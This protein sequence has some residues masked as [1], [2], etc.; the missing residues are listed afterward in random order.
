MKTDSPHEHQNLCDYCGADTCDGEEC[1]VE[2]LRL[3]NARL[4]KQLAEADPDAQLRAMSEI[5]EVLGV[6]SQPMSSE[7]PEIVAKLIRER[8]EARAAL[9]K[10]GEEYERTFDDAD[11]YERQANDLAKIVAKLTGEE[12]G[13]HSNRNCP[14]SR[15]IEA[16][17]DAIKAAERA[18]KE[19]MK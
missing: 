17:R 16:G 8:D 14:I 1:Q 13:E 19:A 6:G 10:S 7:L 5:R 11:R 9:R 2:D 18:A 12:I 3:I 15:A 4:R